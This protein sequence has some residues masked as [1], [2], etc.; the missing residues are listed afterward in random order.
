MY[1]MKSDPYTQFKKIAKG[2]YKEITHTYKDVIVR[3]EKLYNIQYQIALFHYMFIS[4]GFTSRYI[5]EGLAWTAYFKNMNTMYSIIELMKQGM[6][7]SSRILLRYVYEFLVIG[8]YTVISKN[9]ILAERWEDGEEIRMERDIFRN[10][11]YPK[12]EYL[13]RL[14]KNLCKLAHGTVYSQQESFDINDIRQELSYDFIVVAMLLEMNYHYL[15]SYLVTPKLRYYV[16]LYNK[17][18]YK[19]MIRE[20]Q[21]AKQIMKFFRTYMKPEAK[22]A[23]RD[24]KLTWQIA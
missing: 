22:S 14:W 2:N 12:S 20:R 16:Q 5:Y 23:I 21:K 13:K 8:K 10:I 9:H 18:G 1:I 3:V 4:N 24:Y 17:V 7:G 19:K 11:Q 15:N 6:I